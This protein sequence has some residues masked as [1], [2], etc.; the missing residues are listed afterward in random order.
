MAAFQGAVTRCA[1]R[2][3]I[4]SSLSSMGGS[5]SSNGNTQSKSGREDSRVAERFFN[6]LVDALEEI[7]FPNLHLLHF[8]MLS[9]VARKTCL[10][11][12]TCTCQDPKH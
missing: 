5:G 4:E 2:H 8:Q 1:F 9:S 12:H 7:E 11:R 6:L 10:P 3:M